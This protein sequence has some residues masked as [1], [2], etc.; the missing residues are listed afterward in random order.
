MYVWH[1]CSMRL[2]LSIFSAHMA[3][4]MIRLRNDLARA[5]PFGSDPVLGR[6]TMSQT[7][8]QFSP[9]NLSY[10]LCCGGTRFFDGLRAR[11]RAVKLR[12]TEGRTGVCVRC[13]ASLW[14]FLN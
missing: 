8:D 5:L 10:G 3:I 6:L 12:T 4:G 9:I 1:D 11:A 7:H 13:C 2:R 14:E